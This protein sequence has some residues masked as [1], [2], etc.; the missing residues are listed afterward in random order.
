MGYESVDWIQLAKID[1]MA[2]S[3]EHGNDPSGSIKFV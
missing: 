2:G 1:S 3:I